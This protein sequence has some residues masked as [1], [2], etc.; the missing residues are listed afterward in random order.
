MR[1]LYVVTVLLASLLMG[2]EY[3][4][5]PR[6]TTGRLRCPAGYEVAG[7]LEWPVCVKSRP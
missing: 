5:E 1:R 7:S 3:P 6:R 2:C 4:T